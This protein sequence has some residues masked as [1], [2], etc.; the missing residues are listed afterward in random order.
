MCDASRIWGQRS[1]SHCCGFFHSNIG[2]HWLAKNGST[3]APSSEH[4]DRGM[5]PTVQQSSDKEYSAAP[6]V[7]TDGIGS[8]LQRNQGEG[9]AQ[10]NKLDKEGKACMKHAKK[11][12]QKLKSGRIPFSPEASLWICHVRCF[13]LYCGG[14][15]VRYAIGVNCNARLGGVRSMHHLKKSS[16]GGKQYLDYL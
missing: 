6:P 11:K 2:G 12:C 10:S 1:P 14:M 5:C 16:I 4:K 8:L 7:G 13:G 9:L 3:C 15:L